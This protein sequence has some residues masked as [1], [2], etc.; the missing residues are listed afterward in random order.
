[1]V[2]PKILPATRKRIDALRD[3][4]RRARAFFYGATRAMDSAWE[5]GQAALAATAGHDQQRAAV[6][7]LEADLQTFLASVP[8]DAPA[9]PS[10]QKAAR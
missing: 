7:R 6:D 8:P 10:R 2:K 9:A 5:S 4:Y 3:E 1:V